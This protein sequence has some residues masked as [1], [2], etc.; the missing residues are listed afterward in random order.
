MTT[1][2][3]AT[4]SAY[5]S[6]APA[7]A[8]GPERV[9]RHLAEA[10]LGISPMPLSGALLVDIGA[11]TGVVSDVATRL[12]VTC[13]ETDVAVEMLAQR[14]ARPRRAVAAD[15]H[16][17]PFRSATFDAVTAAC[18]L[19]HLDEPATMLREARRVLRPGG[20]LLA[21]AFPA[22]TDPH[23]VRACVEQALVDH[24]Y[25]RPSWYEHLKETGERRVETPR[26]LVDLGHTAGFGDLHVHEIMVDT[27]MSTPDAL[28]DYRLGM[29]QHVEFLATLDD[30]TRRDVR[31]TAI[32][33]LGPSPPAL[34]LGL[35]VLVARA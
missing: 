23:P 15:G 4:R 16:R 3:R 20:A 11:G 9:Y 26:S 28:V 8:A 19:S 13:I 10:L 21:S 7:W 1:F 17:L 25:R 31:A 14:R 33:R 6:A 18:S 35:L 34:I 29:A 2:N 12:G 5:G 22:T 32:A 30:A 27:G 24:G